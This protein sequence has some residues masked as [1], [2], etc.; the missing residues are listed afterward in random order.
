MR[1]NII[2]ANI[3]SISIIINYWNWVILPQNTIPVQAA[4]YDR[5]DNINS[6]IG[7]KP[8][9][10]PNRT[11][12]TEYFKTVYKNI[13]NREVDQEGL[14]F[15]VNHPATEQIELDELF[16][17]LLI[18]SEFLQVAPTL[19]DKIKEIYTGVFQ[20]EPDQGGLN[21]WINKYKE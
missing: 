11:A 10:N 16:E 3:F 15:W 13:F 12:I 5:D 14:N 21:F 2:K 1:S 18:E 9:I 8:A 6:V 4:D 7:N 19:E 20:R 17:N